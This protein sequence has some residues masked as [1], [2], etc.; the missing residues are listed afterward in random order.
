MISDKILKIAGL[1]LLLFAILITLF[2]LYLSYMVTHPFRIPILQTPSNYGMSY[3]NVEFESTDGVKLKGWFIPGIHEN[4]TSPLV[5][6]SH[7]H[8]ANKGDVL[9]AA[10]VLHRNGYDVFLFD[11]RAH[12]ESGGS[13]ATLGWLETNDLKGAIEYVKER[14]N[15][16]SIG[17]IGFSMGGATAITV[18]GQ[19]SDI[20]AV[21]SDSAFAYR[22]EVIVHAVKN[23]IPPPL[24]YLTPFLAQ[25][26]GLSLDE[27]LPIDYAGEISPA[28]LLIIQ[29]DED[30]LVET[31]DAI[32]LYENAKE[33]K[34]LWIVPDTPHVGAHWTHRQEYEER[35]LTFFEEYL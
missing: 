3:E 14:K 17:V 28:A 18:A 24:S 31:E 15:P 11:Y 33:P 20:R 8:G 23:I 29:G 34:E 1:V 35:V 22:T 12:G 16:E 27:N 2:S 9:M 25:M 26:Q 30:I 10:D 5:I 4:E 13:F 6:V 7:G 32:S 21:V 19:T